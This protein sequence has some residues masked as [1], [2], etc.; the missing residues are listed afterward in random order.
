MIWAY[1]SGGSSSICTICAGTPT[2]HST[3][4]WLSISFMSPAAFGIGSPWGSKA[5]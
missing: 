3:S 5:G 2:G 1:T 4:F